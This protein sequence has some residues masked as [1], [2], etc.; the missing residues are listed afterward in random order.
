MI[1]TWTGTIRVGPRPSVPGGTYLRHD[2]DGVWGRER[3]R[4]LGGTYRVEGL[5]LKTLFAR[6]RSPRSFGKI[7]MFARFQKFHSSVPRSRLVGDRKRIPLVS[8]SA[9]VRF[10]LVQYRCFIFLI[11]VVLLRGAKN[12]WYSM[13]TFLPSR[14]FFASS[15]FERNVLVNGPIRFFRFSF[16]TVSAPRVSSL[17][18][19]IAQFLLFSRGPHPPPINVKSVRFLLV[20]WYRTT[21]NSPLIVGMT[22]AL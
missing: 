19:R 15:P 11:R 22:T 5:S 21:T 17:S 20:S 9:L 2:P 12:T 7:F 10:V 13:E 3:A 1:S 8:F 4:A 6:N 14:A 16:R 18:S